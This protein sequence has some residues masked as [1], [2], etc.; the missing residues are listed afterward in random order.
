MRRLI[1]IQDGDA[2]TVELWLAFLRKYQYY[3]IGMKANMWQFEPLGL[4]PLSALIAGQWIGTDISVPDVGKNMDVDLRNVKQE[5]EPK[6]AHYGRGKAF[7]TS[8]AAYEM[9]HD[10]NFAQEAK[11]MSQGENTSHQ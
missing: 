7:Q 4:Q 8:Q 3:G 5:M 2:D 10:N 1:Q 9:L 11:D 6:W